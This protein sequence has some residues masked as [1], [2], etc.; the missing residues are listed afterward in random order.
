MSTDP[1]NLLPP[2]YTPAD[3][4]SDMAQRW[5]NANAYAAK[6]DDT[7]GGGEPFSICI[8]PP[9]VT[10]ALHLGHALNNTLQD[11]LTRAARMQG[12]NAVWL[13]GTH[14]AGIATQTVVYKRHQAEG[15]NALTDYKADE[16]EGMGGRDAFIA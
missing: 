1:Q 3:V 5:A 15:K 9:N 16:A 8:P 12:H 4:E 2:Q 14:H 6:A 11:V 13:P 7:S 10:A